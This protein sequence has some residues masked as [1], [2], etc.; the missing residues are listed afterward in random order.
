MIEPTIYIDS[1]KLAADGTLQEKWIK[2]DIGTTTITIRD[3]I[4]QSKDVGKVFTA[5]TNPFTLPASKTN[6]RIFKRFSNNKVYEGF[7]PRRKYSAMIKLNGMDFK[8]G[9]IRL[10]KVD[11]RDNLPHSYSIQFFGELSSL[12]DILS[13][14]KLKSLDYLS[15]FAF[16]Y[17]R[18]T[19]HMGFEQGFD[20]VNPNADGASQKTTVVVLTRPTSD[21]NITVFNNTSGYLVPVTAGMG[22]RD[23]AE[24]LSNHVN[25]NMV[26]YSSTFFQ[27]GFLWAFQVTADVI[28]PDNGYS[29]TGDYLGVNVQITTTRVGHS[30]IGL[31]EGEY[32]IPTPNAKGQIVFP[33]ISHTRGFEVTDEFGFH[34]MTTIAEQGE[35]PTRDWRLNIFDLKPALKVSEIFNAIEYQYPQITFDKDWLFGGNAGIKQVYSIAFSTGATTAGNVVIHLNGSNYTIAIVTGD[36]DSVAQQ[37]NTAVNNIEGYDSVLFDNNAVIIQASDIGLQPDMTFDEGVTGLSYSLSTQEYGADSGGVSTA[38]PIDEMYMWLHNKKGYTGYVNDDGDS[39]DFHW[40]RILNIDGGTNSSEPAEWDHHPTGYFDARPLQTFNNVA[41][42]WEGV[43]SIEN[44]AGDGDIDLKVTVYDRATGEPVPWLTPYTGSFSSSSEVSMS[45]TFPLAEGGYELPIEDIVGRTYYLKT[46]VECDSSVG[47]F[48]PKL[49]I[50]RYSYTAP[51][52][53]TTN[54]YKQNGPVSVIKNLNPQGLVPDYKI[55]EFL[56]DLFKMYNLVAFEQLQDDNTYKINI[57]SYDY[58]MNSGKLHDITKYIDISKGSVE[59]VAPYSIISY[60]FAKAETFLAIN[61]KEI[62]GDSFGNVDFNVAKFSE[63][64]DGN[65]SLLFDGGKYEVKVGLDKLM[66]ERISKFPSGNLSDIQMGW[67]VNDNKENVPEPVLGKPLYLFPVL[68]DMPSGEV[69]KWSYNEES[70]SYF[71]GGN[72]NADLSQ[73]L[74]FNTEFDEWTRELNS[75]SLFANFHD[76]Y[77]AGIYSPYA[78]KVKVEAHLTPILFTSIK[79]NDTVIIDNVSFFIEEMDVNILTGKTR[80]TL[81]RTTDRNVRLEGGTGPDVDSADLI[82]NEAENNWNDEIFIT[83]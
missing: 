66:Y 51:T 20:V 27:S 73:T 79:L 7:D 64:V 37:I 46:E 9:Y 23:L 5:Y 44:I 12:K 81:L 77:I 76:N 50:T 3:S 2:A 43:F 13:D 15:R 72:V 78:K 39:L 69:I 59:R 30:G 6:N 34:R 26:G 14:S 53:D 25:N 83:E 38:S 21:G 31:S 67:Y 11:M 49:S 48:R 65:N 71:R 36:Q 80:F 33:L 68:Q 41:K 1:G 56:K 17:D 16:E 58:Y 61:Q 74:H 54:Y 29:L 70:T 28:G 82:W 63:G 62:T 40:E 45:F 24:L 60:D 8:K 18:P 42:H 57:Q 35:V 32:G 19:V 22:T 75:N 10:N 52:G 47:E 4:K 55:I